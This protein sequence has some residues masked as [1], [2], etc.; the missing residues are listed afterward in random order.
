MRDR[1]Y[2]LVLSAAAL[3]VAVLFLASVG[4]GAVP[5]SPARI[6]AAVAGRLFSGVASPEAAIILELRLPRA[7]LATL[8]GAALG[9]A[10]TG[11]QGFFRNPLAD[12]YIIGAS[13]GAA[14]GAAIA[15]TAGLPA[16]FAL[17]AAPAAAFAGAL[18]ATALTFAVARTA[19]DPPAAATLLLA[20]SAINALF[21]AALSLVLV[22]RDRDLNRVYYWLL[23]GFSG[24]G[25]PDVAGAAAPLTIG[26]L[27]LAS[28]ARPLDLLSGGEASAAGLGLD[29]KRARLVIAGGAA[30]AA[31][32][33]VAV[34]GIIGFV[35]LVA[36]H[37]A[38]LMVGPGHRRLFPAAG[39]VGAALVLAADLAA[40]VL[41]PPLELPIGVVT[42]AIGAPFFLYLLTKRG[43]RLGAPR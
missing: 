42:S 26:M 31:A 14:L 1:A 21:S 33:A 19:G 2:R 24:A 28:A 12:P 41:A 15:M 27:L 20:G 13:S 5:L 43:A 25:W 38:R 40:R 29:V 32:S 6:A 35:G 37:I 36:P 39:L 9:L 22:L 30:L 4:F 23:G 18:A 7:V 10:G 16:L 11:F 3:S 17:P 8:V 34:A